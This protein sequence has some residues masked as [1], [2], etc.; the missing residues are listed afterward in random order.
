MARATTRSAWF[1][2]VHAGA[3]EVP[4]AGNYEKYTPDFVLRPRMFL[5]RDCV[6]G[7]ARAV[8]GQVAAL[9]R[10][11]VLG[12]RALTSRHS[13]VGASHDIHMCLYM[14]HVPA[15]CSLLLAASS[16]CT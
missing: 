12:R 5:A 13:C 1:T 7:A 14:L 3:H 8:P 16:L 4:V 6:L 2:K 10:R 15:A 11:P 9:E